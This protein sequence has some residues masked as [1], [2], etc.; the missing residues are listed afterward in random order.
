MVEFLGSEGLRV[1][2]S[3]VAF[4]LLRGGLLRGKHR[5]VE[6]MLRS[7]SFSFKVEF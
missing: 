1:G 6:M 2:K 5:L 3:T 4:W 7:V